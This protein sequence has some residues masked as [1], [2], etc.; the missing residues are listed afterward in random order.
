MD[1]LRLNKETTRAIRTTHI[2]SLSKKSREAYRQNSGIGANLCDFMCTCTSL[3][4]KNES[5]CL[6]IQN[7]NR[8]TPFFLHKHHLPNLNISLRD[9]RLFR[10]RFV[11]PTIINSTPNNDISRQ[12]LARIK[13]SS[14]ASNQS[15][16]N[17]Q[18][19]NQDSQ[20]VDKNSDQTKQAN[21]TIAALKEY[22]NTLCDFARLDSLVSP[23]LG[24]E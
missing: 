7:E 16:R 10:A 20:T 24:N 2:Q 11:M 1:L 9:T 18:Q 15:S 4:A 12:S 13:K 6:R 17:L 8:L 3:L 23:L 22:V 14:R 21:P 5:E 19:P